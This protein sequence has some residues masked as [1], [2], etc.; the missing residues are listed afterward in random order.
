MTVTDLFHGFST[1]LEQL[2]DRLDGLS[3]HLRPQ[4]TD[5]AQHGQNDAVHVAL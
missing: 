1:V 5:F 2:T 3:A 4:V